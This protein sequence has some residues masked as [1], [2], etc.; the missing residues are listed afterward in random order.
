MYFFRKKPTKE[1]EGKC[2]EASQNSKLLLWAVMCHALLAY[3]WNTSAGDRSK[4]A[5]FLFLFT[6]H[7]F[8]QESISFWLWQSKAH[9]RFQM[10]DGFQAW[11][12]SPVLKMVW[13]P[14]ARSEGSLGSS[15]LLSSTPC[16]SN[17]LDR[18]P[19]QTR[20]FFTQAPLSRVCLTRHCWKG[21]LDFCS[22]NLLSEGIRRRPMEEGF[23]G[24]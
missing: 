24:P 15:I 21:L 3:P 20:L 2:P 12:N 17:H 13:W 19:W 11:R 23:R 7:F 14:L 10:T 4:P 9:S 5:T 18:N 22:R 1:S 16:L 6:P 8:L